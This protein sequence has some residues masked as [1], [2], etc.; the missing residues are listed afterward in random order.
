[1]T[2]LTR[3]LAE[4]LIQEQGSTVIIPVT[5]EVVPT[6]E[7]A[8][9]VLW[10][11]FHSIAYPPGYIPRDDIRI[12]GDMLDMYGD[13]PHTNFRGVFSSL[14]KQG[15]FVEVLGRPLTCFDASEYG[16][17]L[18]VDSEDIFSETEKKKLQDVA[19]LLIVHPFGD[20]YSDGNVID[21]DDDVKCKGTS[22]EFLLQLKN[23][24]RF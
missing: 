4:Q 20:S 19:I 12:Q 7:R 3:Q 11:Q 22:S 6:P 24:C 9:R 5:A 16:T 1:M 2:S 13:H 17:L 10:D 8:K 15:F 18:I 21:S 14:R 23:F